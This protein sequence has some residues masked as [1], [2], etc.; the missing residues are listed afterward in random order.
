M[1]TRCL[2][3]T[4]G[5][6][7]MGESNERALA[8]KKQLFSHFVSISRILYPVYLKI[9]FHSLLFN[10]KLKR[11]H[12]SRSCLIKNQGLSRTENQ[13]QG[14]SRPRNKTPEI[15]GFSRVFKVHTNPV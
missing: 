2:L 7:N 13:F 1:Q 14:L 10:L 9:C 12:I 3:R 5:S 8:T 15:Q 11:V 4:S 6:V